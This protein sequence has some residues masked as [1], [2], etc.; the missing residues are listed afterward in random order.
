MTR[1]LKHLRKAAQGARDFGDVADNPLVV[2]LSAA[3]PETVIALLDEIE[4][5]R[6]AL[7]PFARH[8]AVSD[9]P[10]HGDDRVVQ[11][12]ADRAGNEFPIT[13][14]DGRAAARALASAP[15]SGEV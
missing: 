10:E 5:L 3:S 4:R 13:R 8:F 6:A 14:G 1:D 15:S 2:Y 7:A 12:A 11:V 9:N